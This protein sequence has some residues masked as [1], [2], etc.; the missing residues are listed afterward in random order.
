MFVGRTIAENE[1]PILVATV[2]LRKAVFLMNIKYKTYLY[3]FL[4]TAHEP[5]LLINIYK[6]TLNGHEFEQAPGDGEGEGSLVCCSPWGHKESDPMDT[7][8]N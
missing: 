4:D 8:G 5:T 1:A 2:M 3:D 7:L 6:W